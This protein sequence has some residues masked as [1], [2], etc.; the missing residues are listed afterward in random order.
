MVGR[1]PAEPPQIPITQ[2]AS[3]PEKTPTAQ[4]ASKA[5]QAPDLPQNLTAQ[6]RPLAQ[7]ET[8]GQQEPPAQ[9]KSTLHQ[10]FR[11][12]QA[13]ALKPSPPIQRVPF[14][15][16]E[17]AS[18]PRPEPGK[19]S[20]TQQTTELREG[21]RAQQQPE[22]QNEPPAQTEPMSQERQQQS[23]LAA[24]G[25]KSGEESLAEWQF[26][27]KPNE[28]SQQPST[29]E[30]KTFLEWVT[31][32]GTKPD[33][34]FTLDTDSPATQGRMAAP[35]KKLAFK[36]Q[37][38]YETMSGFGGMPTPRKKI[39]SQNPRQY[40]YTG[41]LSLEEGRG[42]GAPGMATHSVKKK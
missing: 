18:H 21:S 31:D 17:A 14:S 34:G 20:R 4:P 1:V 30:W 19:E 16:Q 2:P 6:Q 13:S 27:S 5:Q 8:E 32:S 9:Q 10:E 25:V 15:K 24:Q 42:G 39:S 7:Q 33:V 29:S 11:A 12:P 36:D 35:G 41:E 3:E 28:P 38:G 26:L 40:R 37:P 22:P 23:D